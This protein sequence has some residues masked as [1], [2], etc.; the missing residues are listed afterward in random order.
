MGDISLYLLPG[1][2]A[3]VA[4]P[5][6]SGP[7]G[8]GE[9]CFAAEGSRTYKGRTRT[10]VNGFFLWDEDI[11]EIVPLPSQAAVTYKHKRPD[12]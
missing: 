6:D 11:G 2:Q 7:N 3:R 1:F 12:S 9:G 5:A 4:C 10:L 8:S